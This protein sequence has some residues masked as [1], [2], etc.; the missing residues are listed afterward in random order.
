M[1]AKAKTAPLWR[2]PDPDPVR[3]ALREAMLDLVAKRGFRDV[4]EWDVAQRAGLR[5]HEFRNHFRSAD[6]CY[7]QI[8]ADNCDAVFAVVLD[9]FQSRATWRDGV[10]DAAYAVARLIRA[11]PREFRF[12][13]TDDAGDLAQAIRDAFLQRLVDL[14]DEGRRELDDPGSV[15]RALAEG[16]L[17]SIVER[18]TLALRDTSPGADPP[19]I[20]AFVPEFMYVA[21]SA[22]IGNEEAL[23]EL[24]MPAPTDEPQRARA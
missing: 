14:V 10:R 23:E 13:F 12:A 7:R 11:F 5:P 15:S 24:T 6:D 8:L 18:A 17:G 20:E 9:A 3:E 21:V 22:Y 16:V 2:N 4:H 1:E 19:E